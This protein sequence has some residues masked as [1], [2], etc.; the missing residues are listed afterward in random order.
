MAKYNKIAV[1][2]AV[3]AAIWFVVAFHDLI[4]TFIQWSEVPEGISREGFGFSGSLFS[5][6]DSLFLLGSAAMV[7]YLS[8]IWHVLKHT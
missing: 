3:G 6:L 8:R 1:I 5:I 2:L 7:E 4:K